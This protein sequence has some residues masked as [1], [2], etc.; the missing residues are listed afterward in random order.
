MANPPWADVEVLVAGVAAEVLVAGVAAEVSPEH[1]LW[2]T[3]PM[4]R[5]PRRG[6]DKVVRAAAK[7]LAAFAE[8][9]VEV[10][11]A[12]PRGRGC[13]R[14][15]ERP[16]LFQRADKDCHLQLLVLRQLRR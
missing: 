9:A 3:G 4:P 2:A 16:F 10:V 5:R 1:W 13:P 8:E 14:G 6:Q 12:P 7:E 11:V 15:R